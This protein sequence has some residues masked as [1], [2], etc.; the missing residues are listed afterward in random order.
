MPV[1]VARIDFHASD[2]EPGTLL[3]CDV[4]T[5]NVGKRDARAD[6]ELSRNGRVYARITGWEDWRF[7]TGGG[8]FEVMRQPDRNLLAVPQG[9]GFVVLDDPRWTSAIFEFLVRRYIGARELVAMGGIRSVQ[10][11]TDWLNGR[12]AAKDAVRSL[13]FEAG[14]DAIFPGEITITPDAAGKPLVTGPFTLDIRVS[15][16]H[17]GDIAVA[18]AAEGWDPGIDVE[19]IEPRSDAFAALALD[20]QELALLPSEQRDEW[21]TRFW[22]AKEAAGK[23]LGVGLSGNPKSLQISR[24]QGDRLMVQG[25]WIATR[26]WREHVIAWTLQ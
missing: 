1:K 22:C 23:A 7:L 17:K 6:M 26:R 2:P 20:P 12:I 10:R 15:I 11:R 14:H 24:V 16:A 5:R 8:V 18:L 13:L 21:L 4:W 9:D 25:R 19:K 3:R